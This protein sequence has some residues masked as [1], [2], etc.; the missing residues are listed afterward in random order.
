MLQINQSTDSVTIQHSGRRGPPAVLTWV[1]S[2]PGSHPYRIEPAVTKESQTIKASTVRSRGPL[3]N[4]HD[5]RP[6][7][8]P[9]EKG[10]TRDYLNVFPGQGIVSGQAL[11]TIM[12]AALPWRLCR[13]G[14][15]RAVRMS[16]KGSTARPK[17]CW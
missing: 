15:N 11:T 2:A 13:S 4:A 9:A 16:M 14:R 5:Q 7:C 1:A 3:Q 17:T 8:V 12:P 10:N 6:D